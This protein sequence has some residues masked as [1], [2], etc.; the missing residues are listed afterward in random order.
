MKK[1]EKYKAGTEEVDISELTAQDVSDLLDGFEKVKDVHILDMLFPELMP[2]S[3]VAKATGKT[4]D[5]L[6]KW[7]PSEYEKLA[8]AVAKI[9]PHFL[10][11]LKRLGA[12]GKAVLNQKKSKS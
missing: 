3:A 5:D 1:T 6:L 7:P 11:L 4:E 9:N 12:L 10:S 8:A 2:V